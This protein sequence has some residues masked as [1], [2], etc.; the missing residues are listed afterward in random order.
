[1]LTLTLILILNMTMTPD[2][3]SVPNYRPDPELHLDLNFDPH[4]NQ[5]S[6]PKL[7]HELNL[8]FDLHIDL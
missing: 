1:M 8:D 4:N 3:A 2:T 7:N 5:D 6:G